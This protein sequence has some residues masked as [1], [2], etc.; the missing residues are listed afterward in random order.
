M[1]MELEVFSSQAYQKRKDSNSNTIMHIR[2]APVAWIQNLVIKKM[3][4]CDEREREG[5]MVKS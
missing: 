1:D 5:M 3:C 2:W 4:V